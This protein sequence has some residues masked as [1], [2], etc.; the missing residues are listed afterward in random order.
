ML[1]DL[2]DEKYN[3]YLFC[4]RSMYRFYKGADFLFFS[5]NTFVWT[6]EQLRS[7]LVILSK[8]DD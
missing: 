8:T 4:E 3:T 2:I 6:A 5:A 7:L 1:I